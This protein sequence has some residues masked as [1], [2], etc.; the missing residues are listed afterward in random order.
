MCCMRLP[1]NTERKKSPSGHHRTTLSGYIFAI[2]ARIDNRKKPVKQQYLSH[3]SL[4]YGEL[5]RT[6][7]WDR[8]VSL[9]HPCKFQR[10]LRLP[11]GELGPHLTHCGV[12]WDLPVYQVASW[13]IQ[14]FGHNTPTLQTD[15]KPQTVF[16][17]DV[18]HSMGE[19]G[20]H[21]TQCLLAEAYLH[22]KSHLDPSNHLATIHEH[23]RQTTVWSH[24]ANRFTNGCP[25][26][27]VTLCL[28][29]TVYTS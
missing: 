1:E 25:I 19:L 11:W 29:I 3:M 13:P 21:L 15:H 23:Y 26:L 8:F 2:K 22:T 6:S 14:P 4:Q 18:P 27:T 5:W 12:G 7:G 24:R 17:A 28:L 16:G 10:V 20:L 9:G